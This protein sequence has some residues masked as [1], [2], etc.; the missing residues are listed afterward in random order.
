MWNL[1]VV[2]EWRCSGTI[3]RVPLH[4]S[5]ANLMWWNRWLHLCHCLTFTGDGDWYVLFFLLPDVS[6]RHFVS[7]SLA[8]PHNLSNPIPQLSFEESL[9]L[10]P[11]WALT[12]CQRGH[13]LDY[14]STCL[15]YRIFHLAVACL[16]LSRAVW[17]GRPQ[18]VSIF[19][20][21]PVVVQPSLV[22]LACPSLSSFLCS[23]LH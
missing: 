23:F 2:S 1:K 7:R 17:G 12:R 8:D 4:S 19:W 14:R 16:T 3:N 9:I 18:P 15:Q 11:D 22:P 13:L 6:L 10:T 21:I 20:W 5:N